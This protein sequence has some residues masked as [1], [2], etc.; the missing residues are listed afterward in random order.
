ML[1]LEPRRADGD[2]YGSLFTTVASA[3][4]DCSD[5]FESAISGDC[6]DGA[7]PINPGAV[8]VI[9]DAIDQNCDGFDEFYVDGDSDTY[10]SAATAITTDFDCLDVGESATTGDCNDTDA[11]TFPGAAE[12]IVAVDQNC[13]GIVACYVD[14]DSDT[15]GSVTTLTSADSDCAD[16]GE[17][18]TSGDCNDADALSYPGAAETVADAVDQNCDGGDE[19][20]VDADGDTYGTSTTLASADLDCVDLGESATFSDCNDA[21]ALISP[22]AAEVCDSVDNDCAGGIDQGLMCVA[23]E[24]PSTSGPAQVMIVLALFMTGFV[25]LGRRRGLRA[26]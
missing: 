15:H 11:L 18:A 13:D 24:V 14:G 19:C 2:T 26:D 20:Y 12:T 25:M 17:S 6:F 22:A 7:T 10:G 23:P 1:G 8:E 9:A 16:L 3:D 21:D 5:L 4:L